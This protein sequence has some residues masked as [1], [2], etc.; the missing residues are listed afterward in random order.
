MITMVTEERKP[1]F[2]KVVGQNE[3]VKEKMEKPLGKV[4]LGV[5]QACNQAFREMMPMEFVAMA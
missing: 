4:L 5:K 1:L 2:G 3:E